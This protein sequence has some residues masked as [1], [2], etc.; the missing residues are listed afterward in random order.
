M[1]GGKTTETLA[2]RLT[3]ATHKGRLKHPRDAT[4]GLGQVWK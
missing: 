1:H 3:L 4:C 2:P